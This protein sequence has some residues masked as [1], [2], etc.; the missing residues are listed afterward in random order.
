[1]S[2]G[3]DKTKSIK[4][5][6]GR[7]V[8][9]AISLLLQVGYL[10]NLLSRAGKYYPYITL[11]TQALALVAVVA[12]HS[13]YRSSASK[14][15]WIVLV[16]F[17]PVLGLCLYLLVGQPWATRSIRRR[18]ENV[19]RS[20]AGRLPQDRSLLRAIEAED[21]IVYGQVRYIHEWAK[22][23]VYQNTSVEFHPQGEVAFE[24]LKA[25]LR[26][27]EKFIFM[28]Y[29]AIELSECFLELEAI[30][31]ER[32]KAG[33]EV[34]LFYD[35]VGSLTFIG[36][37]FV[38]RMEALGIHCRVFNPLVPMVS[39]FMNNR[40]HRK[41][42]VIDGRV[43][44][45]GGY[46]LADEYFNVKHPYGHW[47]DTGVML[48]GEA[49]RSLTVMFLEMWNAVKRVDGDYSPYTALP[50]A[51][52]PSDGLVQPYADS[53]L[54]D[55]R[56]G[57]NVYLNMLKSARRYAWIT[58]PYLILDDEMSCELTLAA[59]RGVDV[60]IITPGIPDKKIVYQLTRSYYPQLARG[61]V[62]IYEYTP[63]FLHAKQMLVDGETAAVGTINLDFRSLYL[64]FEN[65]VFL[66]DCSAIQDIRRDF[67]AT[68]PLCREVTKEYGGR[69]VIRLRVFQNLL[70][71]FAPLL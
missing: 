27:A 69:R 25:E 16:L 6:V 13:Q 55:E 71:L 50:A 22:Y 60:R 32:A 34:R 44:F 15:S 41:I 70:R 10:V 31:A 43:G 24:A 8:F 20:L 29:H 57:E 30:L 17:F 49:V 64:H 14:I 68:F 1:M 56:V 4:N 9:V 51:E 18:F 47:K 58:T 21:P 38:Q 52:A 3:R 62:R 45:T 11:A 33:V 67:E 46:N 7:A 61:G 19:D 40:D 48:R 28:E 65:G 5:S 59:K 2:R 36:P 42:T 39:A 66:H 37:N 63:G 54:D 12:I 23:P 26:K 35:D 53:P